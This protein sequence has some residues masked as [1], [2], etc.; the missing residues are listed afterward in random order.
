MSP[1]RDPAEA[2]F[3]FER[4]CFPGLR[5][6]LLC[7]KITSLPIP[8]T[9]RK[10]HMLLHMQSVKCSWTAEVWNVGVMESNHTA[11]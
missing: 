9:G 3:A 8:R 4:C 10:A 5:L 6:A 11:A 2:V 7:N 1:L